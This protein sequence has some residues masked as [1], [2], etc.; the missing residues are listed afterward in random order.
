[1]RKETILLFSNYDLSAVLDAQAQGVNK[2]VEQ[3]LPEQL[4]SE[5]TESLV[6]KLVNELK[7][8]PILLKEDEIT[9]EQSEVKVDVSHDIRR[10]IFDRSRPFYIDGIRVTYYV[11]FSGDRELFKC[12]PNS[13]S[14][15]PPHARIGE[16]ELLFEYDITDGNVASS[17]SAF[18]QELR[19]IK[20]WVEWGNRQ[21]EDYNNRL[22]ET[23]GQK[24]AAR[25]E[26]LQASQQQIADL[27]FK[28]RPKTM[29]EKP[30]QIAPHKEPTPRPRSRKPKSNDNA[31]YDV[32]LSF[33]GEDRAY[34]EQVATL[35]REV[36]VKVFYD[37]FEEV[38][39][40][41]R[42]LADHLAEVYAKRSRFIVMFASKHYAA[43]AWTNHER[44]HALARA[45]QEQRIIVLPVRFDDT[46][47]PGLPS[48]VG[49]LDLRKLDPEALVERILKK[50]GIEPPSASG[51][52]SGDDERARK[53]KAVSESLLERRKRVYE[54][55]A[56]G[57]E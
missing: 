16:H 21:V 38:D 45:L 56:K 10:A 23:I 47:I 42:D 51:A 7:V 24:L 36:G 18:D 44:K 48:T 9:V 11:P 13:F 33:A 40:W 46:E 8:E 14:L 27:G 19:N 54:E 50:L 29:S 49:Y 17:R 4:F 5:E 52:A 32:A 12:R 1:M 2:R 15:N 57:A 22:A 43:K 35:L 31:E 3:V 34:V 25:K 6:A 53:L 37:G 28:V 55:L 39:L 41:G 26:R 30:A 20:Q